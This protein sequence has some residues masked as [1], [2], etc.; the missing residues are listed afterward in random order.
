MTRGK[1]R[2]DIDPTSLAG[3]LRVL[4]EAVRLST[5][6]AVALA[7][8]RLPDPRSGISQASMSRIETGVAR[9][10]PTQ[11]RVLLAVYE[12]AA[13]DVFA[14]RRAEAQQIMDEVDAMAEEFVDAR[15]VLQAGG[16]HN[17]QRRVRDA[18][19]KSTL[20]R[21]YHPAA[22]LGILQSREYIEAVFTPDDELSAEDAKASVRERLARQANLADESRQWHLLQT[23][24][25]LRAPVHSYGLQAAQLEH[26]AEVAN[27]PNVR[28]GVIPA[29]TV[30]RDPG[31]MTGFHIFGGP[32]VMVGTDTGTALLKDPKWVAPYL[33][34]FDRLVQR[35]VYGDEARALILQIA[36]EYRRRHGG[37]SS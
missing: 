35:A 20:V 19:A 25:A 17:F 31:P 37:Q 8:S 27:L 5:P 13:P 14:A 29:D 4:R 16:A 18:E 9:P 36:A 3:R 11:V 28:L 34:W 30:I 1:K 23:E 12:E 6:Q 2:D 10:T 33:A 32:L 21:S 7:K 26:I 15:V 24:W 22:I